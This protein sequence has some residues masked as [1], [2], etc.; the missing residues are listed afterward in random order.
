ML[1]I[2]LG[3]MKIYEFE[4]RSVSLEGCTI[5]PWYIYSYYYTLVLLCQF[6][7]THK[8]INKTQIMNLSEEKNF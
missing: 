5:I 4:T 1:F 7:I 8:Y 6:H 3:D 2:D